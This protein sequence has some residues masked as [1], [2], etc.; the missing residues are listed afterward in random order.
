MAVA[1]L[2]PIRN[3]TASRRG[4][5]QAKAD[6]RIVQER[7]AKERARLQAIAERNRVFIAIEKREREEAAQAAAAA[8]AARKS[9]KTPI[10]PP[11]RK[12][13]AQGAIVLV[14]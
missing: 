11:Q 8:K 14:T 3:R 6:D 5:S 9:A 12:S 10:H 7:L 13:N 4:P 1:H 2:D